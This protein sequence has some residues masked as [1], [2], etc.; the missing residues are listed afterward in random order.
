[1]KAGCVESMTATVGEGIKKETNGEEIM[2]L[3]YA[4]D[5][6]RYLFRFVT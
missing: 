3:L 4:A 2:L 1:M 5:P 6:H